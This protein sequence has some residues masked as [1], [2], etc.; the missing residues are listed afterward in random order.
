MGGHDPYSASKGCAE[1][2]V[3]SYRRSFFADGSGRAAALA[4]VRAGN[5]IGGGDWA[6]DRLLPDAVRAFARGQSL[7]VRN[8]A[9]VRPWQ[10][11]LEPL[12][13]YLRLAEQLHADGPRF[14]GAWNFGP[15]DTDS[16]SVE[17]VI[18]LVTRLWGE[19]V[20]WERDGSVQ[21]HEARSLRL[22]CSK[23]RLLLGWKPRLDL[24]AALGW[25]VAW[26]KDWQHGANIRALSLRDI[27]RYEA[28]RS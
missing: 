19:G 3:A 23:A 28:L 22:D 4:S 15:D 14:E 27:N 18:G 13:G 1:L 26:Y 2:V 16:R 9:A 20:A 6:R 7:V 25:V 21:P 10:H 11:V 17:E 5:V 24:E 12:D 8:P